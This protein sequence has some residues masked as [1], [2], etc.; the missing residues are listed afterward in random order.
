MRRSIVMDF[1]SKD[2]IIDHID[3]WYR[4]QPTWKRIE[5][6][7]DYDIGDWYKLNNKA[8]IKI[9]QLIKKGEDYVS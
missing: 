2:Y 9:Y 3:K 1:E 6:L 8:K 5:I 4:E 7:N